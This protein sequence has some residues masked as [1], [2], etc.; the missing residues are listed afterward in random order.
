MKCCCERC[1]NDKGNMK[2]SEYVL[3]I[4]ENRGKYD[5]I[6]NKRLEY[7]K[8]FAITYEEAYAITVESHKDL[9]NKPQV[10]KRRKKGKRK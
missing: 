4:L 2:L 8:Q 5:Y 7:L 6:S 3:H 10:K 9:E 1:N